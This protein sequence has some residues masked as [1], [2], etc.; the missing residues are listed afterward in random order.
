MRLGSVTL[1]SLSAFSRIGIALAGALEH[2][3]IAS[4]TVASGVA[5]LMTTER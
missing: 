1:L 5:L 2:F 4:G 3:D